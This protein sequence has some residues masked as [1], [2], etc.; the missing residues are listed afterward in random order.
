M[1]TQR[2]F[3]QKI[4]IGRAGL[5]SIRLIHT[6]DSNI[7]TY[8][9]PDLDS[10]PEQF[11]ERLSKLAILRDAMDRAEPVEIEHIQGNSG[12]EI[13]MAARI[14]R[15]ALAPVRQIYEVSGLVLELVL[16]A[17]NGA[18]AAGENH[19]FAS[20]TV[21]PTDL[22]LVKLTLD[23]QSPERLVVNEQLEIIRESQIASQPLRFLV[24]SGRL[25][26]VEEIQTEGEEDPIRER[27]LSDKRDDGYIIAVSPN[28][29]S[30]IF[31]EDK[32][33]E[34]S[35]FVESLSLIEIPFL[36]NNALLSNFAHVQFTS[37]PSFV[38]VGNMVGL[39]PFTP[40][41]MDL[42]VPKNS[43][44]Y[45][46]FEAGLRDNLRMRT[47]VI[48]PQEPDTPQEPN[49]HQ[50]P[51]TP[52][53][54]ETPSIPPPRTAVPSSFVPDVADSS[55]FTFLVSSPEETARTSSLSDNPTDT[56]RARRVVRPG[57]DNIGIAFSAEL[58]APL[59]SASRPVWITISRESLDT[60]PDG[61]QPCTDGLPSSDLTPM[62]LRDLRLPY[63]AVWCG[64]GC[65]NPGTYRFQLQL[66]SEFTLSVDGEPLCLH[67]ATE[68][69]IKLAHA[70][71]HGEH[72]IAIAMTAWTCTDEFVM[73][74]YRLR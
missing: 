59:S 36:R 2:G 55:G 66:P 60:G 11:N 16:Q 1:P 45:S 53:S 29:R 27:R 38:G 23:L 39:D 57:N 6:N 71:L 28:T 41:T 44:T 14:S 30:N 32:T 64:V 25:D 37:A 12:Q 58:L 7:G 73:D 17:E 56:S 51:E 19:D 63:P 35:G 24:D 13:Q 20:I 22:D 9:I 3:V 33:I 72:K 69:G 18:T 61:S 15:D 31:G 48:L 49:T 68:S 42:I 34:L 5:V 40:T 21:L 47:K 65:F 8:V 43:L 62:S 70:C 54:E 67:D 10:D 4:E 74:V 26:G 46:L 50:E 52:A